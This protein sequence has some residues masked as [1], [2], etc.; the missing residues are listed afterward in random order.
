MKITP[1]NY[2]YG[3]SNIQSKTRSFEGLWGRTSR[4]TDYDKTLC[5]PVITETCY[6]YPFSDETNSEITRV[7]ADNASADIVDV[8]GSTKYIIKDCRICT[9]L[10]LEKADFDTYKMLDASDKMTESAKIVHYWVKDKFITN[11]YGEQTSASN[12]EVTKKLLNVK[13]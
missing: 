5:I 8:N 1:I 13:A 9:T 6:Y 4:T 7:A 12:S 11:G 10:P 2:S 3:N